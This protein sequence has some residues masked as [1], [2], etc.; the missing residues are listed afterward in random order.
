MAVRTVG[1]GM[2]SFPANFGGGGSKKYPS[3]KECNDYCINQPWQTLELEK[4]PAPAKQLPQGS[5]VIA[6][7]NR[8]HCLFL[9]KRFLFNPRT[10][11]VYLR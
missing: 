3:A 9:L 7:R 8:R 6:K 10:T 2:L 4:L 1:C 11:L 5:A